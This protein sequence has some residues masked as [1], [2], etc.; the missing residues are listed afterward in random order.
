MPKTEVLGIDIGGTG[1]KT[2]AVEVHTGKITTE[3]IRRPTPSPST[4]KAVLAVVKE[5][6]D[7]FKW[8]RGIGCGF[9]AVIRKGVVCTAANI[10]KEW[11]GVDLLAELT[12]MSQQPIT[13]INDADA[14]ALAEMRFGAGMHRNK[15]G[16]GVVLLIT[17]GTGIGS[18]LFVDGHLLPNTEFGHL[19]V[20]GMEAEKRAATVVQE[21]ENLIWQEWAA[22]VNRFLQE[23][24]KLVNPDCIIIGGGVSEN[25]QKFFPYLKL[26][27]E[28]V[29]AKLK[30]EAGIVGA[31]LAASRL[32]DKQKD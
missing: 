9:P 27:A 10:S 8:E 13:V 20:D 29:L 22:R 30:N 14:A 3:I 16:G 4:P 5:L 21:Q 19:E 23:M 28:V 7:K 15:K 31:A 18:A 6:I 17:L 11:I 26:R 32:C 1:I 25:P 24:E 12:K 2:A